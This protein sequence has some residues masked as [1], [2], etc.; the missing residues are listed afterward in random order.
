MCIEQIAPFWSRNGRVKERRYVHAVFS[1]PYDSCSVCRV[2]RASR[3]DT[4]AQRC[5][6]ICSAASASKEPPTIGKRRW[7]PGKAICL[8]GRGQ[9][10]AWVLA[11]QRGT[12]L[13]AGPGLCTYKIYIWIHCVE[14][15]WFW[16][17]AA[18]FFSPLPPAGGVKLVSFVNL[19]ERFQKQAIPMVSHWRS[20]V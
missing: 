6:S 16:Q 7:R 5:P 17:T 9:V 14:G 18:F 13:L 15:L 12:T 1:C 2:A 3:T 19:S 20:V 4:S 11:V 10:P 8:L